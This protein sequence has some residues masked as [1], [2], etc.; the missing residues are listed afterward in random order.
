MA[1]ST[2][3]VEMPFSCATAST[4]RSTSARPRLELMSI[5]RRSLASTLTLLG[6]RPREQG[7]RQRQLGLLDRCEREPD[8]SGILLLD[9]DLVLLQPT[10]HAAKPLAALDARLAFELGLEAGEPNEI[11]ATDQRPIDAGRADLK[12]VRARDRIGHVEHGRD[13]MADLGAVVDVH[14]AVAIEWLGHHLQG[15]AAASNHPDLHQL[16]A[17]V[18][19]SRLDQ[20]RYLAKG[21]RPCANSN[22]KRAGARP[23]STISR[24]RMC[25]EYGEFRPAAQAVSP[26]KSAPSQGPPSSISLDGTERAGR[27]R[28]P[29]AAG[30][31]GLWPRSGLGPNR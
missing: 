6:G 23:L 7:R 15:P 20:L 16:E 3:S 8:Q 25:S 1:S 30:Q 5:V 12:R 14:A 26:P 29:A 9:H 24:E 13:R 28:T 10:Y 18:A 19:E 21:C 17:H 27:S 31:R 22:T 4:T 2:S 11:L